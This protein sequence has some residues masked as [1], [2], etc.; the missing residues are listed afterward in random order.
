MVAEDLRPSQILT[1]QA[2]EN[3]I[4]ADMAIRL[5]HFLDT[6]PESWLNQQA[7]YDIWKARKKIGKLKIQKLAA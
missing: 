5:A 6:T 2:F 3:A 7:Q 1:K 4:T